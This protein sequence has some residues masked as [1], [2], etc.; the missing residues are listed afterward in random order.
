MH[1]FLLD[2]SSGCIVSAEDFF[3]IKNTVTENF[4]VLNITRYCTSSLVP[5]ITIRTNHHTQNVITHITGQPQ[6]MQ[7]YD[8]VGNSNIYN[9]ETLNE[10]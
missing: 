1:D 7:P 4:V 8:Q 10:P 3:K 9:Y 2:I 5:E 6:I